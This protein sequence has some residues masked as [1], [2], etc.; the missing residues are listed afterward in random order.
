MKNESKKQE[1]KGVVVA[2]V[3]VVYGAVGGGGGGGVENKSKKRASLTFA[4]WASLAVAQV[5][6]APG[7]PDAEESTRAWVSVRV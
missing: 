2:V 6:L 1:T 4:P 5:A 3:I 7:T